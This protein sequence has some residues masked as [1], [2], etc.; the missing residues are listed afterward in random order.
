ME[1]REGVGQPVHRAGMGD[2][3]MQR[4]ATLV[5]TVA[6]ALMAVAIGLSTAVLIAGDGDER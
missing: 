1:G 4:L 3:V 5:P 6:C 2:A